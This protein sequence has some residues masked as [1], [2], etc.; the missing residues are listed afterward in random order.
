MQ[1]WKKFKKTKE[2][3][4]LLWDSFHKPKS[5][6]R[7]GDGENKILA[8][9][10]PHEYKED[11][12]WFQ[13]AGVELEE[14]IKEKLIWGMKESDILGLEHRKGQ[15]F[16]ELT[17]KILD[18]YKIKPKII[19]PRDI[20]KRLWEQ[21]YLFR[22]LKGKRIIVIG[23]LARESIKIF[24][25]EGAV[26]VDY[27]GFEGFY[28]THRVLEE[29][30]FSPPFDVVL[31]AAGIPAVRVIPLIT[32]TYQK[33]A[34]DIGH[35]IDYLVDPTFQLKKERKGWFIRNKTCCGIPVGNY[36]VQEKRNKQYYILTNGIKFLVKSDGILKSYGLQKKDY[37]KNINQFL[38]D[39]LPQMILSFPDGSLIQSP[40]DRRVFYVWHGRRHWI[41]EK[42][43]Y[44]NYF[45]GQQILM[46]NQ[47]DLESLPKG[48]KVKKPH[49]DDPSFH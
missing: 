4:T 46:V 48:S 16:R 31:V 32:K 47:K 27:M 36:L 49:R 20:N 34:L 7:I 35:V 41:Y 28:D 9:R 40:N 33:M 11:A 2:I 1:Y 38:L 17:E 14:P 24:Q 8:W 15:V 43:Y 21:G 18:Y 6:I 13:Y 37:W 3:F 30:R 10:T 5:L 44:E 25:D 26:V 22:L 19:C 23:R 29:L 39:L 42:K 12:T 45:K